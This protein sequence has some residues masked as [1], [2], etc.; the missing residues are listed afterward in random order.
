MTTKLSI[1]FAISI[2]FCF[3]SCTKDTMFHK[4]VSINK[5]GWHQDSLAVFH[6]DVNDSI[7]SYNVV[8]DVR[9]KDDYPYQ[10]LYLFVH[11]ISPDTVMVT[12]TLNCILADNQ[13]RWQG[14]GI[15]STKSLSFLYMKNI[16]FPRKGLYTFEIRQGMRKTVLEGITDVGLHIEK[17]N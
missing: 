4:F 11:S 14:S 8:I 2:A 13:G 7:D 10:N 9:N 3:V 16:Q 5:D 1:L 6:V 15:G 12:D 17:V